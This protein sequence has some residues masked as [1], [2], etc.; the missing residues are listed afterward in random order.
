MLAI[1]SEINLVLEFVNNWSEVFDKKYKKNNKN[2][3]LISDIPVV[4]I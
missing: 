2:G 1:D 3:K 4:L